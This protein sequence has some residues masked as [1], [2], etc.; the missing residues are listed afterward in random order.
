MSIKA[1]SI[2]LK[3]YEAR[4]RTSAPSL[5]VAIQYHHNADRDEKLEE[6]WARNHHVQALQNVK[7]RH[8]W[9]TMQLIA[10]FT[11]G[12]EKVVDLACGK[13]G[14]VEKWQK[15]GAR[16]YVG[17]DRVEA[18]L[19]TAQR[20]YLLSGCTFPARFICLDAFGD[21]LLKQLQAH[22]DLP[23]DRTWPQL[24]PANFS[25][26]ELLDSTHPEQ[27]RKMLHLQRSVDIKDHQP[28]PLDVLQRAPGRRRRTKEVM[29]AAGSGNNMYEI[30]QCDNIDRADGAETIKETLGIYV[31][32]VTSDSVIS[33]STAAS[34]MT[35]VPDSSMYY[36]G[37]EVEV[38][39]GH[40]YIA[41]AGGGGGKEPGAGQF[42]V[43]SCQFAL[44]YAWSSEE[45]ARSALRNVAAL[46]KPGGFFIGT[47][48]DAEVVLQRLQ[49]ARS[50][51]VAGAGGAD[52][53]CGQRLQF[54]N[55]IYRLKFEGVHSAKVLSA[56]DC[57]N[58]A[59]A[60]VAQHYNY[61]EVKESRSSTSRWPCWWFGVEY[62]FWLEG[63]VQ[64]CPEWLVPLAA[65]Q[66]VARFYALDLVFAS[67]FH[68]LILQ[69]AQSSTTV[70]SATPDQ[71]LLVPAAPA[72]QDEVECTSLYLAF[73][74]QKRVTHSFPKL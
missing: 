50:R 23:A 6:G 10:M 59:A 17:V 72:S 62:E 13:G 68:H 60:T 8:A 56:Y 28:R 2:I 29:L 34:C 45:R 26:K 52:R 70:P 5:D 44:H 15:A 24:L 1:E 33:C 37:S 65:L 19:H 32:A 39:A 14:D 40:N 54:G 16:W 41:A 27:R 67:N 46:L 51:S 31:D 22:H 20:I 43:C 57:Q 61:V 47:I 66:Q 49:E 69:L 12:G 4:S 42:D 3:H 35:V 64:D 18:L 36:S 63:A 74:F 71:V 21:M 38:A 58:S 73:A 48:P 55:E 9:I 30:K 11:K 25:R 7:H 53:G